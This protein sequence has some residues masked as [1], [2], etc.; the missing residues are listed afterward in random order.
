M[1]TKRK[2]L[3]QKKLDV[4][5]HTFWN[6]AKNLPKAGKENVMEE[7]FQ[8]NYDISAY[9]LLYIRLKMLKQ[10]FKVPITFHLN[11]NYCPQ[12]LTG[13]TET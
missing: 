2:I 7:S 3:D 1:T 8:K 5:I 4:L 10:L 6:S 9:N 13:I 12:I 11:R